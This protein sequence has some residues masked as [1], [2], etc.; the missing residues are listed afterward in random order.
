MKEL[1]SS[2][3]SPTTLEQLVMSPKVTLDT[4]SSLAATK[5]AGEGG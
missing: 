1:E 4:N 5:V 3:V 2:M